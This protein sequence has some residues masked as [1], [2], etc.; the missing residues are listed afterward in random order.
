MNYIFATP[1]V[2]FATPFGVATDSL[3]NAA[4]DQCPAREATCN[5]CALCKSLQVSAFKQEGNE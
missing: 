1:T 4:L 5:K 3:R 2:N